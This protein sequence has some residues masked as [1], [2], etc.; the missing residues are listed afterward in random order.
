MNFWFVA[1]SEEEKEKQAPGMYDGLRHQNRIFFSFFLL[2][3][4]RYTYFTE[5]ELE[6]TGTHSQ[7]LNIVDIGW[8]VS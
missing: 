7:L 5:L 2:L 8:L 1:A 3:K 4:I 6:V